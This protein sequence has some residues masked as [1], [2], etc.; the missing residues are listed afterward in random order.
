MPDPGSG[1]KGQVLALWITGRGQSELR[2]APEPRLNAGEA[3]VRTAWSGISRGTERL[4]YRGSIPPAEYERMTSPLQEGAFPFPVKYGYCSV[5]VV[6]DGPADLIGRTV[7]ALHPHQN[8]F[9]APIGVMGIVPENIPARRAV[10]AANMETAL[11][12]LWDAGCGPADRVVVVGGGIVG[13]LVAYLAGRLPGTDVTL[14][15]VQPDRRA[16]AEA[17]GARFAPAADAPKEADL[18][19]H[20]SATA[21]GLDL[22]LS[23]AG[24]EAS[25]VEMSWYGDQPVTIALGSAFHSRRL[26]LISSQVGR[27]APSRRARWTHARR[28]QAA[29]ALL[30][31]PRLDALVADEV[32]FEDLPQ[33]LPAILSPDADGLPPVVRYT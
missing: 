31:D 15:D 22:A 14:V 4:V 18:V 25:V 29:L 9:A 12:A 21:A 30:D 24:I 33:A 6:E 2:A 8:R 11:N 13:L 7:F 19:F 10:L 20:T 27:V 32:R 5:G 28:L 3:L 1:N 26:K 17:L 23:C 16:L